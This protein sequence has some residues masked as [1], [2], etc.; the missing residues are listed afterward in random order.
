MAG[1][2]K[3][4]SKLLDRTFLQFSFSGNFFSD[5]V[6]NVSSIRQELKTVQKSYKELSDSFSAQ[7]SENSKLHTESDLLR[8]QYD[9]VCSRLDA[10]EGAA[11]VS[12]ENLIENEKTFI[13]PKNPLD[14]ESSQVEPAGQVLKSAG[15]D[16]PVGGHTGDTSPEA[17]R[18]H[19]ET[20]HRMQSTNDNNMIS[21]KSLGNE[22]EI[23]TPH[24]VSATPG[25]TSPPPSP[26]TSPRR[27]SIGSVPDRACHDSPV[28]FP[29]KRYCPYQKSPLEPQD[30]ARKTYQTSKSPPQS[31]TRSPCRSR[32][33]SPAKFTEDVQ[34]NEFQEATNNNFMDNPSQVT[35]APDL[36]IPDGNGIPTDIP[37]DAMVPVDLGAH[38]KLIPVEDGMERADKVESIEKRIISNKD[39]S[40]NTIVPTEDI[41]TPVTAAVVENVQKSPIKFEARTET[42]AV[43]TP[44]EVVTNPVIS[45]EE[46]YDDLTAERTDSIIDR[47]ELCASVASVIRIAEDLITNDEFSAALECVSD[48]LT[49]VE[50]CNLKVDFEKVELLLEKSKALCKLNRMEESLQLTQEACVL[51]P[52]RQRPFSTKAA[53]LARMRKYEESVEAY[54]VALAKCFMESDRARIR[55]KIAWVKKLIRSRKRKALATPAKQSVRPQTSR[56]SSS[57]RANKYQIHAPVKRRTLRSPRERELLSK[58]SELTNAKLQDILEINGQTK[59]GKKSELVDRVVD[60]ILRGRIPPCPLC[61]GH[62]RFN[63]ETSIYTCPGCWDDVLKRRPNCTFQSTDVTRLDWTNPLSL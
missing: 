33:R 38:G 34:L 4:T 55:E 27:A 44:V 20:I 45:V 22:P 51:Q 53:I 23:P 12:N 41:V 24:S 14:G 16:A 26:H 43:V 31:P 11:T 54:E 47:A 25:D 6:E 39:C 1:N 5:L 13:I 21:V 48:L 7:K 8:R 19:P 35:Q 15:E 30:C 42:D 46:K 63:S 57:K 9:S 29:M 18:L 60:G 37:T 17:P 40:E 61:K 28:S 59:S 2:L 36:A 49:K 58:L 3:S 50:S 32:S 56:P 52:S 10:L 62:L